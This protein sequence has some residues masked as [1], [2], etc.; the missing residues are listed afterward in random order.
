MKSR[1]I[2]SRALLV[3]S[4]SDGHTALLAASSHDNKL[5]I[6]M[7]CGTRMEKKPRAQ[8]EDLHTVFGFDP[9]SNK[10]VICES[11][12]TFVLRDS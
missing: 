5:L 9:P 4:T 12:R 6:V 1:Q 2:P 8:V 3:T 10:R 7:P 11:N